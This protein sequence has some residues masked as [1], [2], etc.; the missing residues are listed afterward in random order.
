MY[1]L[2]VA[3]DRSTH[4]PE[5]SKGWSASP[6][7]CSLSARSCGAEVDRVAIRLR[8]TLLPQLSHRLRRRDLRHCAQAD[9]LLL[10]PPG[11]IHLVAV[12]PEQA[13]FRTSACVRIHHSSGRD[14]GSMHQCRFRVLVPSIQPPV[15]Q[16]RHLTIHQG[17]G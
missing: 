17:R 6:L 3:T 1:Q 7:P 9:H 2:H 5:R 11:Q 4:C 14:C 8:Q 15:P 12:A 16:L 10:Y 13:Q